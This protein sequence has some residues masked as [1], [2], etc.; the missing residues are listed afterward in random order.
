MG[1]LWVCCGRDCLGT[2]CILRGLLLLKI[3][4]IGVPVVAQQI[5]SP[6]SI[7][8]DVGSI[9]GLTR[10]VKDP[11]L[12]WLQ[13][14]PAATALNGS[15]AWE[16]PYVAGVVLK[17]QKKKICIYEKERERIKSVSQTSSGTPDQG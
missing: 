11:A 12:L 8:E 1:R 17:I 6:T 4:N 15:L 16:P 2:L 7:H 10:W 9:P 13:Y 3:N 5:T 14:R